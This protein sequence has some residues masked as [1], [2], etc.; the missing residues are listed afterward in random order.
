MEGLNGNGDL[1][2]QVPI[3]VFGAKGRLKEALP[4]DSS[5]YRGTEPEKL[6]PKPR[7]SIQ[8]NPLVL[9]CVRRDDASLILKTL[10]PHLTNPS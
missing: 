1:R 5:A 10:G 7:K 4:V 9:L 8:R 3:P 2:E 6:E